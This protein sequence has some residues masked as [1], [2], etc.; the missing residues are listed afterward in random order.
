MVLSAGAEPLLGPTSAVPVPRLGLLGVVR[1]VVDDVEV[2]LG[3]PQQVAVL[4]LLALRPGA[5][6]GLDELVD[7]LWS[8]DPPPSAATTVRTYVSR[9]RALLTPLTGAPRLLGARRAYRL[10]PA[11]TRVDA[12]YFD[13]LVMQARSARSDG[14]LDEASD[15]LRRALALWRG[16]ALAGL[17]GPAPEAQRAR[18]AL[19]HGSAV[20]ERI[21]VDLERG[22]VDGPLAELEVLVREHPLRERLWELRVRALWSAGRTAEALD[23]YQAARRLLDEELGVEPG[24]R[25]RELQRRILAGE[26]PGP[27]ATGS[28]P[29]VLR[30]AGLVRPDQLPAPPREVVGREQE[31][32]HLAGLL[33]AGADPTVVVVSGLA[34]VGKSS[35]V[36]RSARDVA[37]RFPDGVLY[38]DLRGFDPSGTP[39]PSHTVARRFVEALGLPAREVPEDPDAVI[40]LYR[41]V[42]AGRRLLVVLDNARDAE[43]V[44]P[45]VPGSGGGAVVVTSRNPL[46]GL[47]TTLGAVTVA[48]QPLGPEAARGLLA[49]HM[50]DARV[51]AEPAALDE[52]V[53]RSGGLPLTLAVLAARGALHPSVTLADLVADLRVRAATL[54][55][56]ATCDPASD[57]RAV[58]SWSAR[59]LDADAHLLLGAVAVHPG[60]Y[61]TTAAAASAAALPPA[62][63]EAAVGALLAT[64]LLSEPMPG[65]FAQHDLV[66]AYALEL[67]SDDQRRTALL[68]LVG[69]YAASAVEAAAVLAPQR[70]RPELPLTDGVVVV[71]ATGRPADAMHCFEVQWAT[72]T[73]V[74]T[75]AADAGMVAEVSALVWALRPAMHLRQRWAEWIECHEILLRTA[76]RT[77]DEDTVAAVHHLLALGHERLGDLAAAERHGRRAEAH[78]RSTGDHALAAKVVIDRAARER[79]PV[80]AEPLLREAAAL[81]RRAGDVATEAAALNNLGW[82]LGSHPERLAESHALLEQAVER[83]TVAGDRR[84]AA[85]ARANR[86]WASLQLDTPGAEDDFAASAAVFADLGDRLN[87]A[88]ALLGLGVSRWRADRSPAE[89]WER[90]W[91]LLPDEPTTDPDE[92]RVRTRL[93]AVRDDPR[94]ATEDVR[95]V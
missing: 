51:A 90:A 26:D 70:P 18:L 44:R 16:P 14:R 75:A 91:R 35:L 24:R 40:A 89:A 79:D 6:V 60:P 49:R 76:R 22:V 55:G 71:P 53:A 9:L 67:T 92:V 21:T 65:R 10:D 46:T 68:R 32:A 69:H 94:R 81:A 1:F 39:L 7:G 47:M 27:L 30:A 45:L 2:A 84:F 83:F 52:L 42:T 72:F 73:A 33:G 5:E 88:E 48:L 20:E 11:G 58:I 66:R 59:G 43:Q 78:A 36:R 63:A 17:P 61:L 37:D 12:T 13:A 31:L 23:A 4:A 28:S 56:W 54:D 77:G 64:A 74:L 80:V 93:A 15:L 86:G 19:L 3:S 50:G 41:S 57:L 82:E 8:D 34:G 29:V 38:A 85:V 95:P 25:L 62:R 87:E